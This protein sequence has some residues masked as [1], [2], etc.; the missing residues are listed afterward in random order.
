MPE[1]GGQELAE[2][3]RLLSPRTK[4]LFCSGYTE[5]A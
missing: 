3:L 1:M 2:K 5:D 4:V